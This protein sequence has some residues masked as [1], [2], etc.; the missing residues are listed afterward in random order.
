MTNI[1]L[2][3]TSPLCISSQLSAYCVPPLALPHLSLRPLPAVAMCLR[4]GQQVLIPPTE[5]ARLLA[6]Y[7]RAGFCL[8]LGFALIEFLAQKYPSGAFDILG[9]ALGYLAIR[10]SEGYNFQQSP[11]PLTT[12]STTHHTHTH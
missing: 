12:L 1:H 7:L 8:L 3:N 9:V 10:S 11:T 6:D 2:P 5:K 4:L